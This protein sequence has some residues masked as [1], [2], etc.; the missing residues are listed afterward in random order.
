MWSIENKDKYNRYVT[1]EAYKISKIINGKFNLK[2]N[3]ISNQ[4][5]YMILIIL[6]RK[7]SCSTKRN[8]NRYLAVNRLRKTIQIKAQPQILKNL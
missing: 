8:N 4:V 6:F 2:Q 5:L 1:L 7:D 3:Y